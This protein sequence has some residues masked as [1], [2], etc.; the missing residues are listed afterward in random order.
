MLYEVFRIFGVPE[1]VHMQL[2]IG[3]SF[4]VIL[5]TTIRSYVAH[6]AKGYVVPRVIRLWALP[7]VIGVSSAQHGPVCA[8]CRFKLAFVTLALFVASKILFAGD[9]WNPARF[10]GTLTM[11]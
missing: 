11:T 1:A 3:T 5:P 7:A 10:P 6:R 8:G 4:A 2:C 9:R